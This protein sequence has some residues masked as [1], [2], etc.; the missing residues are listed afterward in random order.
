MKFG[1]LIKYNIRNI[2]LEKS[3]TRGG[4]E[5]IPRPFSKKFVLTLCQVEDY[6]KWLKLSCRPPALISYKAFLKNKKKRSGI[7]LPVSFSAWILKK[8]I[9]VVIFNYLTKFQCLVAFTSWDFGQYVYC[10]CLLTRL[11]SQKFWN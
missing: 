3:Y 2:F 9:S 1:W 11:W 5:T 7:S 6:R 10:N 4:R 8:N